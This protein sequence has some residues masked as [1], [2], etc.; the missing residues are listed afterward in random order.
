MRQ[1]ILT[2]LFACLL[3]C[4]IL[5]ALVPNQAWAVSQEE[6]D[7]LRKE[8]MAIAEEHEEKQAI[9]DELEEQKASVLVRKQAMDARNE[10]TRKEIQNIE[11]EI[12]LY[13]QMIAEEAIKLEQAQAVEE[14]QLERYRTGVRA[15]EENGELSYL[16]LILQVDSLS[17]L[18]TTLDDT[19]DIMKSDKELYD[20]YLS[21]RQNTQAVKEEYE[22]HRWTLEQKQE[23]LEKQKEQLE[24]EIHEATQL[25]RDLE[26]DIDRR[27][28]ELHE[29]LLAE[30]ETAERIDKLVAQQ[31]RERQ[32][33][34][35]AAGGSVTSSGS[36]GWPCPSCT[37][38][39]SRAG[40]RYHPIFG[41]YKYHSGIDIGAAY[42]AAVTAS[43]SG[44]VIMASVNGGYGN[45]IMIDHGNGYYTLYGHLSGYAVSN[46][47]SVSK[48]QTIGYVGDTGWATGPHLHFEIRQGG[49]CLDPE[50]AAGFS[51]LT[52]A[53]DAGN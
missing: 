22:A 30:I 23:E 26:E 4:T 10:L 43:D 48:G 12:S 19:S 40:N 53:P 47:Q 1:R 2:R 18:L 6:I 27:N 25:I 16:G 7:E 9:V 3:L 29:L 28:E 46:G 17:D 5:F 41:D 45:C 38:I 42:G 36:W 34:A 11:Q 31:E 8:R 21:A 52:Y 24:N 32:E 35:R 33:A 44:T 15:M 49:T 14:M 51:G 50:A 39:T 37:Y 13:D 20:D